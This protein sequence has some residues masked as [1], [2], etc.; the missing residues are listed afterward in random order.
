MIPISDDLLK[1]INRD[2]IEKCHR[3]VKVIETAH[4]GKGRGPGTIEFQTDHHC[5]SIRLPKD[6]VKWLQ[7]QRCGDAAIFEFH[8][9]GVNLHIVEMKCKVNVGEWLKAKER[10]LGAY[11]NCLAIGKLL[12]IEEFSKITLHIAYIEDAVGETGTSAPSTLKTTIGGKA[13]SPH[14]TPVA[15]W[16]TRNVKMPGLINCIPLRLVQRDADGNGIGTLE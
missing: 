13:G 6:P 1:R 4:N 16:I 3:K 12:D 2:L 8:A 10:A 7:L 11:F 14:S 5:L 15:E 9:D